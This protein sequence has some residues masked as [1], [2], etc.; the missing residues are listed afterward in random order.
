MERVDFRIAAWWPTKKDRVSTEERP[1]GAL[2]AQLSL[3]DLIDLTEDCDL[4]IRQAVVDGKR[5]LTL[6]LDALGGR[7]RQR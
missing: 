3:E 5:V 7:F 4:M 2:H 6:S 1:D